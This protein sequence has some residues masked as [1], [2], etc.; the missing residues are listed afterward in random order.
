MKQKRM[1]AGWLAAM[2]LAAMPLPTAAETV[3]TD[4]AELFFLE[5]ETYGEYISIPETLAQSYQITLE[6]DYTS[7]RYS[8]SDDA[9]AVSA[10][11]LVTPKGYEIYNLSTGE[12]VIGYD[13]GVYEVTANADGELFTYEITLTDYAQY[14]AES[15]ADQYIAEHI[16]EDMTAKEKL[17][18]ICQFVAGYDYSVYHS[19]MVDMI[20]TGEGGD[21]WAS[22]STVN[23]MCRQLGYRARTRDASGDPGS[24]SGHRNTIVEAD[25]KLYL[26][27]AGYSGTAP[28][29]YRVEE[30]TSNFRYT[31]LADGTAEVTEY[32]GMD[33]VIDIPETVDGYTVTSLGATVICDADSFLEEP[34]SEV[35]LPDT[36]TN[37]GD[38]AFYACDGLQHLYLPAS[39]KT[40][41]MGAFL[42]CSSLEL[43][44]DSANPYLTTQDGILFSKDMTSLIQA[45]NFSGNPDYVVPDGVKYIEDCAF[46]FTNV[47][48]S[49]TFPETLEDIG[50]RA[51]TYCT[52]NG[53]NL[54]LPESVSGIGCQAFYDT[55][56]SSITILNP[57]CEI[58]NT[59]ENDLYLQENG[60]TLGRIGSGCVTPVIVGFAGSTAETYAK[61]YAEYADT[62]YVYNAETGSYEAKEVKGTAYHFAEYSETEERILQTGTYEGTAWEFFWSKEHGTAMRLTVDGSMPKL[63]ETTDG[64]FDKTGTVSKLL[65]EEGCTEIAD[66]AFQRFYSIRA[67]ELPASAVTIPASSTS[68]C[69]RLKVVYGTYGTAAET[70]AEENGYRFIGS[71][72]VA[73]DVNADGTCSAA[74]VVML[75]KF[76]LG[77]ETLTTADAADLTQDGVVNGFDLAALKHLILTTA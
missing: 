50:Y 60:T 47:L 51:F 7:V 58:N 34:V 65:V 38:S 4:T 12:T 71:G 72:S 46:Y 32:L 10:D 9:I 31:L 74:D 8:V 77:M 19:G 45:Y 14:Y 13:A 42:R 3:Y 2:M 27:D 49:I 1:A 11:G 26:A 56:L 40:V 53:W 48:S 52:M 61:T 59:R 54:V 20:V 21:C 25:G 62:S 6:G 73:G 22:T 70:F 66:R 76:L 44:I 16:T 67:I 28:R 30:L 36:I 57:D 68:N 63:F 35:T 33:S 18:Q 15:V 41:G 5:V 55:G 23:Y 69:S 39:V 24:G 43:E 17:E 29:N 75:Q 37:I 64:T